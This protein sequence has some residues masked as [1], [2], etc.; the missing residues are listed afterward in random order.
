MAVKL[1][2]LRKLHE[3][4]RNQNIERQRF[5]YTHRT[6]NF[7]VFFFID[8]TPFELLFGVYKHNLAFSFKVERGYLVEDSE[9]SADDYKKLCK[10]LNLSYNP[11]NKFSP[12]SFL[13]SFNKHIPS[14]A[15]PAKVPQAHETATVRKDVEESDKK[16]FCGWRNNSLPAAT[17]TTENLAK[18]LKWLGKSTHDMC[19]RRNISSKWTDIESDRKNFFLPD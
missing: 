1:T 6:V 9:L 13:L 3:S 15:V 5:A 18:T 14:V 7:D 16:Y 4:M 2:G 11:G 8:S 12:T 19:K 17:V 10:I